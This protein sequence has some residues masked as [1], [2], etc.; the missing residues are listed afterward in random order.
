MV[1]GIV[2]TQDL[3]NFIPEDFA[4]FGRAEVFVFSYTGFNAF[5]DFDGCI[6]AYIGGDEDIFDFIEDFLIYGRFS[7]Y[8]FSEF[9]QETGFGFFETFVQVFF[10]FF[11]KKLAKEAHSLWFMVYVGTNM[12]KKRLLFAFATAES[13]DFPD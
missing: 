8:S 12:R 7:G 10:F 6:E 13:Y 3:Y 4:E 9:A 1:G 11:V 5:N 2:F